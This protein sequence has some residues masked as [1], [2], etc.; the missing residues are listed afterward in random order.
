MVDCDDTNPLINPGADEVCGNAIDDKSVDTIAAL[1]KLKHAV[2]YETK[3]TSD[4]VN[5]LRIALPKTRVYVAGLSMGGYAAL[6]LYE[7]RPAMVRSLTLVDTR[8]TPD[9][10]EARA[11]RDTLADQLIEQGR[12]AFAGQMIPTL[13]GPRASRT[14]RGAVRSMIEGTRYE[15]IVASLEPTDNRRSVSMLSGS[16]A[17]KADQLVDRLTDAGLI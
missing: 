7:L 3:L 14:M 5:K 16:L 15:T 9:S 10:A 8:A 2:L 11:A 1:S 17:E 6:A 13:L 4:G 12:T